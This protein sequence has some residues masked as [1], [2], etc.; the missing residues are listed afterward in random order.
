M[1]GFLWLVA[2]V[3]FVLLS[4]CSFV[5]VGDVRIEL[6]ESGGGGVGEF[7]ATGG[8]V[9]DRIICASGEGRSLVVGEDTETVYVRDFVFTC[10]DATGTFTL[11][12]V[13]GFDSDKIAES[14]ETGELL[15]DA[16]WVV[17]TGT[18]A[19]ADLDGGGMRGVQV[20]ELGVAP[21]DGGGWREV[22]T[23]DVSSG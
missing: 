21:W 18:G 15:E 4:A 12:L 8:A 17:V 5:E 9:D 13:G 23:G 19:Y 6:I 16:P 11:R 22:F 7:V 14:V 20:V 2:G 3:G 1:N 10:D